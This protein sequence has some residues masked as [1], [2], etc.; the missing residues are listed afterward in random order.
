MT[1][2]QSE[3]K[4]K[5]P[6]VRAHKL[7]MIQI[8]IG[9]L[10][11]IVAFSAFVAAVIKFPVVAKFF[12]LEFLLT[13]KSA[14]QTKTDTD[15]DNPVVA[16]QTFISEYK[17]KIEPLFIRVTSKKN[18][19][20]LFEIFNK[21]SDSK[22]FQSF[23]YNTAV[24]NIIFED[25]DFDG[26]TDFLIQATVLDSASAHADSY[27]VFVYNSSSKSFALNKSLTG[28][29]AFVYRYDINKKRK[30]LNTYIDCAPGRPVKTVFAIDSDESYAAEEKIF[31]PIHL[32]AVN[33][34]KESDLTEPANEKYLGDAE[35]F[36]PCDSSFN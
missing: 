16:D 34:G 6:Y 14:E 22:P 11:L 24:E 28:A 31:K 9:S 32:Y 13:D 26:L 36:R 33:D 20:T 30:E 19:D 35:N 12:H 2:P 27:K 5:E 23:T 10:A 25:L 1:E 7:T 8:A 18:S 15:L 4:E 21:K 3:K 29:L 17:A